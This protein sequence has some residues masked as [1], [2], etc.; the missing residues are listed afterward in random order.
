MSDEILAA[1]IAAGATVAG[2]GLV[3]FINTLVRIG[4]LETRV[5]TVERDNNNLG[6]L[7]R[8]NQ[9]NSNRRN[10]A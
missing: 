2:G 7:Y 5:D 8:S 10:A 6:E 1:L 4:K 9:K 3:I